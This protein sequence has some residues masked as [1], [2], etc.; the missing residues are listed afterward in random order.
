ME[1]TEAYR[2]SLD[3]EL[4]ALEAWTATAQRL[5]LR[6]TEDVVQCPNV[7]VKEREDLSTGRNLVLKIVTMVTITSILHRTSNKSRIYFKIPTI[8]EC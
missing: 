8:M 1:E 3:L 6:P 7:A 4:D 2:C 5:E